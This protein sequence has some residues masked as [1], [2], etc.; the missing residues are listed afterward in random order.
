MY[1]LP[2]LDK[3]VLSVDSLDNADDEKTF[4]LTKNAQER[5][6]AIELNRRMIYGQNNT[7]SRLQRFLETSELTKC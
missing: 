6:S 3:K 7:T 4:W 2:Q 5:I 1:K